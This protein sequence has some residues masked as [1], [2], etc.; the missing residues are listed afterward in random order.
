MR[1]RV[2]FLA[3]WV[4]APDADDVPRHQAWGMAAFRIVIGLMWLYNVTWKVPPDFGEDSG[5]GL[6]KFTAFA[7]EHPVLP[8]Y[9]WLVENAILPNIGI[10]GWGVLLAETA[11][12]VML[13]SGTYVRAAALLGIA[14]SVAI[15]LSVAYAPEEWPWSYWLMIGGHVV[16]LVGTSG[17]V[18]AVDGVRAGVAPRALL[19]RFWGV[20]ALVVGLFSGLQSFS[21]PLAA[22]GV[23]LGSSDPSISFG[24][25]N[26]LGAIV[27]VVVGL[28]LLAGASG[29]RRAALAGAG[30]AIASALLLTIQRG[31]YDPLLGGTATSTAFL[32]TLAVVAIG[33]TSR[34]H[35]RSAMASATTAHEMG[36]R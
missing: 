29:P 21:D 25:Y 3:R 35:D 15:G 23:A 16:L 30:L 14:Q 31:F 10:F 33:A 17:R 28:S 4:T 24:P 26:L 32:V 7:V 11:L 22:R 5:S 2:V 34:T 27:V 9:S 20:V 12:A 18:L 19:L 8:P 13:L 36:N 1:D 6:Y